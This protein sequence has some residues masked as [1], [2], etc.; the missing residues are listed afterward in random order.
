MRKAVRQERRN[1]MTGRESGWI[2]AIKVIK[3][4]IA[5]PKKG[6]ALETDVPCGGTS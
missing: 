3:A 5:K 6:M 4:N 2:G 1:L